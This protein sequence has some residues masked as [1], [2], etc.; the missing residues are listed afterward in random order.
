MTMSRMKPRR[1]WPLWRL[2]LLLLLHS[3]KMGWHQRRRR[4]TV[5]Q[6][7]RWSRRVFSFSAPSRSSILVEAA[8]TPT[9]LMLS[10]RLSFWVKKIKQRRCCSI[11]KRI[12]VSNLKL[13][14]NTAGTLPIDFRTG[15]GKEPRKWATMT[16]VQCVTSLRMIP[17]AMRFQAILIIWDFW[18]TTEK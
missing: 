16:V 1:C 8:A 9:V 2:L 17:V 11:R 18:C 6:C 7:E 15:R 13:W 12:I 4:R 14:T 10:R 3:V 5:F